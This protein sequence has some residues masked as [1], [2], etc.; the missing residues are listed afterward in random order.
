MYKTR[1]TDFIKQLDLSVLILHITPMNMILLNTQDF[2]DDT[3][4]ILKG[5]R[6]THIRD[7]LKSE[8]GD[9]LE[10]GLTDGLT[11]TGEIHCMGKQDLIMDVSLTRQPPEKLPLTL[12]LA[13]PRP[14]VIKRVVQSVTTL[15]IKEIYLINSWRVEKSYWQSPALTEA[16]ILAYSLLGL[17]QAKDTRL[18]K[19]QIRKRFKP[20]VEDELPGIVKNT[21]KLTAHPKAEHPFPAQTGKPVSLAVGPEGGFIDYEIKKLEETGFRT[22][23]L[24]ERILKVETVLP[25][26]VG[27]LF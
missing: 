14:K 20:F 6:F 27:K 9:L 22:G 26:L 13:L 4:V 23:H 1:E 15:G 7:V 5:R 3:R 11:G 8:K 18:P 2:T 25:Y 17:E 21:L 12:I 19:I 24:S 16:S 10:V